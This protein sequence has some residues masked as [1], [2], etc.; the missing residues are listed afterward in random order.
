[1]AC[2][3]LLALTLAGCA[4]THEQSKTPRT[5]TEQLLLSQALERSIARVSMPLPDGATV[6]VETAGLKHAAFPDDVFVSDLVASRLATMGARIQKK[7]EDASYRVRV[8]VQALGTDQESSFLGMPPVTSVLLPFALPEMAVYKQERQNGIARLSLE[9][10]ERAT[11]RLITS[12]RWYEGKTYF[13]QY[14]L[15]FFIGLRRTDLI[16]PS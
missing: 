4:L 5:A 11:G 3:A 2:A 15:F 16:R 13:A 7:E 10:F 14:T 1:V 9:F 12:T 8:V 6:F